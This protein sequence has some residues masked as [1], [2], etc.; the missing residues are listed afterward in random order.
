M[1]L[2]A[3]RTITPRLL[4]CR[5]EDLPDPETDASLPV[6]TITDFAS[7]E[8]GKEVIL[9]VAGEHARELITSEIVYWLG[10]L[11]SGKDEELADWAAIQTA[12]ALAWKRF[13]AKGTLKDWAEDLLGKVIFKVILFLLYQK[14]Y[15]SFLQCSSASSLSDCVTKLRCA[16]QII[17]IENIQGR[18]AVEGGDMC[19]RKTTAGV[20]LNRNWEYAWTKVACTAKLQ[21]NTTA[22][23]LYHHSCLDRGSLLR[24]E[25][26]A[27]R[28]TVVHL[29]LTVL[30]DCAGGGG[31]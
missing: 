21:Q 3:C 1:L 16:V 8:V 5:Y 6:V 15:N 4:L 22:P 13:K 25:A 10:K 14:A 20:D 19:L 17:P 9:L 28:I 29:G 30:T 2:T 31:Q 18:K 12:T 27:K 7:G 23:A 24:N 26:S 11:L